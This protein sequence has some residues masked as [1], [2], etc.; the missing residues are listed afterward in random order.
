MFQEVI[1]LTFLPKFGWQ[2]LQNI[3]IVNALLQPVSVAEQ[4]QKETDL[5]YLEQNTRDE[6]FEKEFKTHRSGF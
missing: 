3:C 2:D 1:I 6:G 5:L 4:K